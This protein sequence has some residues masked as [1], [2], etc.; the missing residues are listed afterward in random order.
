METLINYVDKTKKSNLENDAIK[1]QL[2]EYIMPGSGEIE[3][4]II[5]KIETHLNL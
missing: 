2:A 1:K 5:K 3:S 4:L